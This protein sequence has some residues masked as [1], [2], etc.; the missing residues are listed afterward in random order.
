MQINRDQD[1]REKIVL[2]AS[3]RFLLPPATH[4]MTE[5]APSPPSVLSSTLRTQQTPRKKEQKF[6]F[7]MPLK[8]LET[9]LPTLK[10]N[11]RITP[12]ITTTHVT[13]LHYLSMKQAEWRYFLMSGS[14]P[15][16]E[17]DKRWLL[18]SADI[19]HKKVNTS[20][21][22]TYCHGRVNKVCIR[23]SV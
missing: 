2:H 17:F 6:F 13:P 1:E 8:E 18:S 23:F 5:D 14:I 15:R 11:S 4:F 12:F 19:L 7:F 10:Y 21:S 9:A 20:Y 22:P 16:A 3:W